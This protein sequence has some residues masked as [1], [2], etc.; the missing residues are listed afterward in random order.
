MGVVDGSTEYGDIIDVGPV[1]PGKP[2]PKVA[3]DPHRRALSIS[4]WMS[5]FFKTTSQPAGHG[6]TR[7]M[8]DGARIGCL[9]Y[10]L[11]EG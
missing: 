8:I 9:L 10:L 6:F 5:E 7:E 11:S 1:T 3:A 4:Q 2:L